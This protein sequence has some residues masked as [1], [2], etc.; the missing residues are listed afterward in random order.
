MVEGDSLTTDVRYDAS[1]ERTDRLSGLHRPRIREAQTD[2]GPLD[3][4]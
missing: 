2:R 1:L 3:A 4:Q